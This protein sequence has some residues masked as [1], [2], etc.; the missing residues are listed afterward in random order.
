MICMDSKILKSADRNKPAA[1]REMLAL[2]F[3]IIQNDL[4]VADDPRCSWPQRDAVL[5]HH[6]VEEVKGESDHD[7]ELGQLHQGGG[8]TELKPCGKV[9]LREA[10]K[11]PKV[12]A[13]S[14][15]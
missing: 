11:A 14:L 2:L 13:I 9:D 8:K 1:H 7:W 5:A 10:L 12:S 15:D 6:F 3:A 4:G